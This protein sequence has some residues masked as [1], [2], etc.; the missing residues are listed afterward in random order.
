MEPQYEKTKSQRGRMEYQR[1]RMQYHRYRMA[2]QWNV[3]AN[4]IGRNNNAI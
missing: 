4:M 1:D 2:M 3:I